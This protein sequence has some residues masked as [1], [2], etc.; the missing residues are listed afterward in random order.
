MRWRIVLLLMAF[1]F[2]THFNRVSMPVAADMRI[3]DEF[4]ILPTAMGQV[5]S[6]FLFAYTLCM[7]PGGWF[8]DHFGARAALI[9]MGFGSALFVGLTSL[10]GTIMIPGMGVL[11]LFLIIRFLMGVF[12][13]PIYPACGKIVSEWIPLTR[14][15]L[16][17][18]LVTGCAFLGIACTYRVFG[19]MIE[20]FGW[21]TAFVITG[22]VTA[23]LT[24]VWMLYARNSPHEHASVNIMERYLI[25]HG[26]LSAK[27]FLIDA[28]DSHDAQG[29]RDPRQTKQV[30]AP[31]LW[32]DVLKSRSLIVLTLSYAAVGYF[33]DIFAYWMHY[34]FVKVIQLGDSESKFYAG[35]PYLA[36]AITMPLGGWLSDRLTVRYGAR[37]GRATV[38]VAGMIL[39]AAFLVLGVIVSSPLW[40]VLCFTIALGAIGA[41]EGPFWATAIELGGRQAGAAGGVFNT[42]GNI[43]SMLSP[44]ITPLIAAHFGWGWALSF[45]SLVCLAGVC[46]WKWIDPDE[47]SDV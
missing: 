47:R 39:S 3:M 29:S 9:L 27:S 8:G 33:E 22:A 16:A 1:S 46:A 24:L 32:R 20:Y 17:I 10:P 28:K 42:G 21:P 18:G 14:K 25:T 34:Y 35:I 7:I 38:P 5:Y 43:G 13:A 40:V 12:T 2:M 26:T 23:S 6:A 41:S 15:S 45:G 36:M 37:K 4:S 11:V 19:S 30:L 44:A 31:S